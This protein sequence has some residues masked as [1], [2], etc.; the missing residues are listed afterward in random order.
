MEYWTKPK[1]IFLTIIPLFHHS[2]V[3]MVWFIVHRLRFIVLKSS[4]VF[5]LKLARPG[6]FRQERFRGIHASLGPTV[7]IDLFV[8]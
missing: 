6:H 1:K 7:T 2:V 8:P 3:P 5:F 4:Q